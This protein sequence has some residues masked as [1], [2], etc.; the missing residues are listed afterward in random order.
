ML[1]I[2]SLRVEYGSTVAVDGIDLTVGAR[3]AVALLGPN[4]A[5]KSSTLDAISGLVPYEGEVVFDG[6]ELSGLPAEKVARL[7]LIHVPE[8]RKVFPTLTV[9]ENLLVGTSARAGRTDGFSLDDVY[10]LLPPLQGLRKRTGW[11]LSGGE[12]QMVAI[13]RGLVA[14]PRLLMLDEPSLGLA[15]IIVRDVMATIETVSDRI[16]ILIVEQN[17]TAAMRVCSRASV[18]VKGKVVLEGTAESMSNREALIESYLGTSLE[19]TDAPPSR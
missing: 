7:G 10:D 4:G 6:T 17:S 3:G 16:P 2:R 11:A 5:G 13:G 14:A 19:S 1:E 12:Q 8:G 9:H 15:P 18:L